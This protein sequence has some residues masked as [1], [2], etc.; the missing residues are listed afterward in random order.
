MILSAERQGDYVLC[1]IIDQG[2]G[3]PES[4][5]NAIFEKFKQVE[6]ADGKRKSG[7]GLGL[8]ICKQIV[9]E[10]GG[11]IGVDS[12]EGKGS[13]FWFRLPVDETVSMKIRAQTKVIQ[14]AELSSKSRSDAFAK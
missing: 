9:E 11:I 3:V 2:R 7:T 4:H 10:H 6:A 5:K 1:K 8:P 13:T 12:V 14:A